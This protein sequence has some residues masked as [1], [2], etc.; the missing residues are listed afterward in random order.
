MNKKYSVKVLLEHLTE[1]PIF[2]EVVL[3]IEGSY[4]DIETRV[5]EYVQLLNKDGEIVRLREIENYSEPI[6]AFEGIGV[7][8]VYSE[9][10]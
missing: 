10:L 8:E 6:A 7:K 9:Y 5:M 2:E 3:E 1:S 4:E